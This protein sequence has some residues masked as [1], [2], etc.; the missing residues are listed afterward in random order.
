MWKK[1]LV[2]HDFSSSAN[3]AAALARDVAKMC[4]GELV[5]LHVIELPFQI[6]PDTVVTP[7]G[8]GA[9]ISV[10]QYAENAA[11]GHLKDL[12][13]RLSK[14][15]V[16][17]K[18]AVRIGNPVDEILRFIDES[19]SDLTV[20]GTHGRTGLRHLVIGSVAERVVRHSGPPVLTVRAHE[21]H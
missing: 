15:G 18:T 2:P 20:M 17:P 6:T 14:D 10:K 13:D 9:P 19:K 3:Q 5:L 16:T 4:G 12:V 7:P 8:S 1:I 11:A 21:H